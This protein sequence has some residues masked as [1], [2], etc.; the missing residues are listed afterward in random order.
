MKIRK[1]L[2]IVMLLSISLI[3]QDSLQTFLSLERT[4]V[5]QFIKD[6]P[7]FDGRGTIVIILD[8]GVDMGIDGLLKTTTGE[9]K[10]IDVQDFTKQG[11]IKFY[12]ADTDEEDGKI[13]Y[14]NEDQNLKVISASQLELKAEEDNY[15]IGAI[16]E[17]LWMNSGSGVSDVNGNGKE[18]DVFDF[19]TFKVMNENYWVVYADLSG[20]G[21]LSDE[22]PL[23]NYKE[24]LD[25]F[26]FKTED[27]LP[28]FTMGLNIFPEE[29]IVSFHF[30]DGSHGTHCAGIAAG[31]QI[32]RSLFNGVAPGAYL[33][34]M[35]LGNN[36]YS[37]GSTVAESMK[38]AFLYADKISKERNEPCIINMSFGIGSEIEGHA[39]IEK[40]I[41]DLVKENPY[42]YICTSNGNEGTGI[43]TSG[44][45][46]ASSDLFSSGAI[47][48]QE[49]GR[50][51]WGTNLKDDIILYF[52]S[53]GGE[54]SK[55][56][57][58]APGACA[59]T[60][61]NFV[62][63][64]R[65]W[66][67]SMASP[68]TAGVMSLLL[69]AA[70]VEFPDIKI[71]S[72]LLYRVVKES[73]VKMNQYQ[74][75]DQG[76][77]YINVINAYEI[78]KKYLNNNAVNTFE[79]YTTKALSPNMPSNTAPN[80]Y[81]RDARYLEKDNSFR[82]SLSR[83]NFSNEGKFFRTFNIQ[84][85]QDWIQLI[86]KK[87]YL[88]NDQPSFIDLKIDR[89]KL[90][91]P[92][93]YNGIVKAVRDDK[94]KFVEF[95]FMVTAVIPYEFNASNNYEMNFNGELDPG[96]FNR[97]FISVPAGASAMHV[98]LNA[99]EGKYGK[100][101]FRV[102]NPDG[103]EVY[104]SLPIDTKDDKYQ[105]EESFYDL[106]PGV[107]EVVVTGNFS[108]LELS[109]YKLNITFKGI[110]RIDDF[111]ISENH[112][113]I[114]VINEY[115]GNTSYNL[116]G[117][118]YGYEKEHFIN[119]DEKAVYHLPFTLKKNE[120]SKEFYVSVTKED[121]NKLTDCAF[122]ILDEKGKALRIS[123][124]SYSSNSIKIFNRFEADSTNLVLELVP[125]FA[126][127][128]NKIDFHITE[129]GNFKNNETIEVRDGKSKSVTLYPS[130]IETLE[131]KYVLPADKIPAEANYKGKLIFKNSVNDKI[132]QELPL[133]FN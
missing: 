82:V 54:V 70:K 20:D 124:L 125:A 128:P 45:P 72:K 74:D 110:N 113:R 3:A 114:K 90:S 106:V 38:K 132:E 107:Y 41:A 71:P 62:G 40:F 48:T 105:R 52:S 49:V 81:L 25:S 21:D 32:D 69:S 35:K 13:V 104:T 91:K 59:S 133:I 44:I 66:G 121:F 12:E 5:A 92:G 127:L 94:N 29:Q 120:D 83:D 7:E 115:S 65:F 98:N 26:T 87:T 122:Q 95:D 75:I 109:A 117:E 14:Y 55:P 30:D 61:P 67:T 102:F 2:L 89:E 6:N 31:Y 63:W 103:R 73:A 27:D 18:D 37:G 93:L 96:M 9:T 34:S 100:A 16:K 11:D 84:T 56:D 36:N 24:N 86:T 118:I 51:L 78:L 22:K 77:G 60:V 39:E 15:F 68:Y 57:V 53:R 10:V 43:S 80:I 8:T 58:I 97:Y 19:I 99:V 76:G 23:R 131:L 33:M 88:R 1:I 4:G 46:A 50:D 64:D 108:A 112:N 111:E 130:I 123:A 85:N 129:I 116:S 17:S 47:L 101:E 126:N 119:V 79:T 28:P 42:L